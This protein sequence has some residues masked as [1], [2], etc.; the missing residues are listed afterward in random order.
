MYSSQ[1][2]HLLPQVLAMYAFNNGWLRDAQNVT[3]LI[4]MGQSLKRSPR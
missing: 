1:Y 2:P 3:V 4:S